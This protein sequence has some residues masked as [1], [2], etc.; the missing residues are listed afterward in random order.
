MEIQEVKWDGVLSYFG[1]AHSKE[2]RSYLIEISCGWCCKWNV[3]SYLSNDRFRLILYLIF[4]HWVFL[5]QV[6]HLRLSNYEIVSIFN[7]WVV[8]QIISILPS[9][10]N[11]Y[12]SCI[13]PSHHH[14]YIKTDKTSTVKKTIKPNCQS[15]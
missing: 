15:R 3:Y 1:F 7:T 2:L 4:L 11:I 6:E 10:K 8:K 13:Q 5:H 9:L 12:I 14:Y